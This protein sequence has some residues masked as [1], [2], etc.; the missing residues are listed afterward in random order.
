[1]EE[2]R[3]RWLSDPQHLVGSRVRVTRARRPARVRVPA[4]PRIEPDPGAERPTCPVGDVFDMARQLVRL[5]VPLRTFDLTVDGT[6]RRQEL[7]YVEAPAIAELISP[8][9]RPA[10]LASRLKPGTSGCMPST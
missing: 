3:C 10:S 9:K 7:R 6:R 1:M 8:L 2:S 4:E 5:G